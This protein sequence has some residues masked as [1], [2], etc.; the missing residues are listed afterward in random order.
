MTA[1]NNARPETP[2][3]TIRRPVQTYNILTLTRT[4]QT[5]SVDPLN[6]QTTYV[7]SAQDHNTIHSFSQH[8]HQYHHQANRAGMLA[9]LS[10][11]NKSNWPCFYSK[12]STMTKTTMLTS[13]S[14]L[15]RV[16]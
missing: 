14:Y 10:S 5:P 7:T 9:F 15:L 11:I 12:A 4:T 8:I 6:S 13:A 16:F 3:E 1:P 2:S